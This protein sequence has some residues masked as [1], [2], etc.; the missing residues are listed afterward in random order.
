WLQVMTP[1]V[2]AREQT[3]LRANMAR[4]PGNEQPHRRGRASE[5]R[6]GEVDAN[7]TGGATD[8]QPVV[9]QGRN[10]LDPAAADDLGSEH[11]APTVLEPRPE[12]RQVGEPFHK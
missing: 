5:I 7:G 6:I 2:V 3:T 9:D 4:G 12:C 1:E 10:V 11:A 8:R